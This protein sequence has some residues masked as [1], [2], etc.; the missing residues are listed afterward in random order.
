MYALNLMRLV[1]ELARENPVYQGLATKFF[2]HFLYIAGAM[3]N[4]GNRGIALW[5][6][7]DGFFYDVL[8]QPVWCAHPPKGAFGGGF[9][10]VVCR[11]STRPRSI[12]G[13][14]R[15]RG[16]F[17]VVPR[18]LAHL[19]A[20][21]SRWQEPGKG[22]RHLLSILRG[23]RM[24]CLL[25]RM[26]DETEFLSAFGVRSLSK[27]YQDQPYTC[28]FNG[29]AL[30]VTY[31]PAESDTDLYGGNSNWRGPVWFPVNFLLIE[32]LGRFHHYYGDDFRVECPAGSGQ[33]VTLLEVAR[34]LTRR[35]SR[36]FFRDEAG[37][38][39]ERKA[40]G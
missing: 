8:R 15:V 12:C 18:F 11:G 38:R 28:R 33:F 13:H 9:D 1:L 2:E 7:E 24:K 23:H 36:L 5:D 22:E 29:N 27:V 21:T 26:L 40:P 17:A 6:E 20:L 3:T 31:R 10:P 34:E 25:R 4:V 37:L 19:A 39:P 14:A 30:G 35:L 32:S 16:S